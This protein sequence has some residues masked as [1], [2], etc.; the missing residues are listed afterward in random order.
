MEIGIESKPIIWYLKYVLNTITKSSK[1]NLLNCAVFF[2][3]KQWVKNG[4]GIS[5]VVLCN[6]ECTV[7]FFILHNHDPIMHYVFEN[8][9][10]C[11]QQV[12]TYGTDLYKM[13]YTECKAICQWKSSDE[14][15]FSLNNSHLNLNIT[16][17][18]CK[19]VMGLYNLWVK[20]IVVRSMTDETT[21]NEGK[22]K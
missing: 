4:N 15:I 14:F 3:H 21:N 19:S 18:E 1:R 20:C 9:C 6:R 2:W 10:R 7:Y 11:G 17:T 16:V 5:I 13:Y 8:V 22:Y 12:G